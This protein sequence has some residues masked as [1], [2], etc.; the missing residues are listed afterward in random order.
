[1]S[2]ATKAKGGW[3]QRVMDEF[4]EYWIV[5]AFLAWFFAV[6]AWYRRFV[7]AE[8]HISYTH[9]WVGL[10]EAL[11]LAK[12]ILI[13]DALRLGRKLDDKPLIVPTLW[14]AVVFSL[15]VA[16]F[17]V[18]EHTIE[19]LLRHRGVAGGFEELMSKGKYELLGQSLIMFS[20]F[21]PFFACK[22]L[23]RVLGE[24]QLLKLFFRGKAAGSDPSR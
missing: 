21:V 9:Y 19:G 3:K 20:V 24:G 10:I 4:I 7:L 8:Y 5:V 15:L 13:G 18:L 12:L 17:S 1:M 11:V 6:F 22:E 2:T 23:E 16:V 14:K